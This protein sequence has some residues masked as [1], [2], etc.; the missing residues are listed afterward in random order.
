MTRWVSIFIP[1]SENMLRSRPCSEAKLHSKASRLIRGWTPRS[2]HHRKQKCGEGRHGID[3]VGRSKT[4]R[5][6]FAHC[7]AITYLPQKLEEHHQTTERG[8]R[9]LGLAQFH[10][11][12]APKSGNFPVH[13]FVLLGVSFNQLK[14]NRVRTK[15]CYSIS[16]F[17]LNARISLRRTSSSPPL[18]FS[19]ILVGTLFRSLRAN[20]TPPR[21]ARAP[22]GAW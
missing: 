19:G 22:D 18:T 17:R 15:Q 20:D 9:S 14:L 10:F 12:S 13:C 2:G 21:D 5:Q 16:E 7:F 11:F 8:D 1:R 4:K 6:I 3:G